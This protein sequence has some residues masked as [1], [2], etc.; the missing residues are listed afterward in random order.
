MSR[1]KLALP[2]AVLALG[3]AG[4]SGGTEEEAPVKKPA[5]T[6]KGGKAHVNPWAKDAP[7]PEAA[8]AKPAPKGKA[9]KPHVNPWAKEGPKGDA[10]G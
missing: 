3:L 6:A 8:A 10:E 5:A 4:C 1:F 2:L 7:A 9:A